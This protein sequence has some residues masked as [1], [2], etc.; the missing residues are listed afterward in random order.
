MVDGERLRSEITKTGRTF[1]FVAD[2]LGITTR[3]LFL[4]LDGKTEFKG[5]EIAKLAKLLDFSMEQI[6][7]IFF[8][9]FVE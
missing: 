9:P 4:K 5:S 7:E 6:D 2:Y 3:A 1:T 8:A